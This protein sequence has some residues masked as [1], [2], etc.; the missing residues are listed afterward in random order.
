MNIV[1]RDGKI[2]NFDGTK[3]ENAV[4]KT[5]SNLGFPVSD[6]LSGIA[7]KV[8][9]QLLKDGYHM[10]VIPLEHLLVVSIYS[11]FPD[12][13]FR[14]TCPGSPLIPAADSH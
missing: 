6:S 7:A 8:E 3:I 2:V 11:T 9:N 5:C 14:H 12:L 13:G 10:D 1:K 4:L